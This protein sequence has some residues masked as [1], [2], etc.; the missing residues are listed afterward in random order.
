VV[1]PTTVVELAADER[2]E[3]PI[4]RGVVGIE[5]AGL[6]LHGRR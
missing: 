3:L 2:A 5:E 6:P 4:D 1:D